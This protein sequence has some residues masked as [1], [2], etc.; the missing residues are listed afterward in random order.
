[1]PTPRERARLLADNLGL[2]ETA[3]KRR[4]TAARRLLED[5]TLQALIADLIAARVAVGMTQED[6]AARM[7]TKKSVVSRLESGS[8]TRPTLSTIEKYARAVGAVI[9]IRVQPQR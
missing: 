4:P 9:E 5:K 7:F 2:V 8:R 6:V 3:R 1:M